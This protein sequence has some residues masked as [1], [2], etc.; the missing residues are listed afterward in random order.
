MTERRRRA[1]A[2]TAGLLLL[3]CVAAC[4]AAYHRRNWALVRP[5]AN[6]FHVWWNALLPALAF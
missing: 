6:M 1:A 2:W 4:Y 5:V 3:C